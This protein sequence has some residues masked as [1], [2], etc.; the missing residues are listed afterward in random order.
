MHAN[1][2]KF[3]T[4]EILN[5]YRKYSHKTTGDTITI[6]PILIQLKGAL[7]YRYKKISLTITGDI[8][9]KLQDTFPYSYRRHSH[10][11]IRDIL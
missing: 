2:G 9:T 11:A 6:T 1:T 7:S 8:L 4:G 5:N 3:H 10:T